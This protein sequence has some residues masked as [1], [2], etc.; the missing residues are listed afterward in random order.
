M[1]RIA[2]RV[3]ERTWG[4][5]R[6]FTARTGVKDIVYLEGSV[7]GGWN[8]LPRRKGEVSV[9]AAEL[10]DAGTR[11]KDKNAIREA[12]AARGATLAFSS[13]DERTYFRGSCLPE[14]LPK[15]LSTLSE[16]L[17]E[18]VFPVA[19]VKAAKAR[20]HGELV[21]ER[22]D[23]RVQAAIGLS[24]LM[25]DSEH[26]NF[27]ETSD[28]RICDLSKAERPDLLSFKKHLGQGGLVLSIDGGYRCESDR[29]RS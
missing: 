16:C 19:E 23:T 26:P 4:D 29:T 20:I 7:L 9:L 5:A 3:V 2:D 10:L 27:E 17:G 22:S 11:T 6:V 24:R 28:E 15:L 18:A 25:Y 13:G 21:E 1:E 14:D 8:M 12:L